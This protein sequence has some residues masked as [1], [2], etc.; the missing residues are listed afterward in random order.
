[1]YINFMD[2]PLG[3]KILG[4]NRELTVGNEAAFTC[5]TFGSRPPATVTWWIL[6]KPL[7]NHAGNK[8]GHIH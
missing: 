8:V 7:T 6:D 2:G 1:M 5:A 4:K 3:V